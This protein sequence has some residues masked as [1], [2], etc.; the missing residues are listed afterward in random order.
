MGLRL[1]EI[2]ILAKHEGFTFVIIPGL[3]MNDA[4]QS[5]QFSKFAWSSVIFVRLSNPGLQRHDDDRGRKPEDLARE[6]QDGRFHPPSAPDGQHSAVK[7]A[8]WVENPIVSN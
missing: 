5:V 4:V 1:D 3:N 7:E 8:R 2:K 6:A